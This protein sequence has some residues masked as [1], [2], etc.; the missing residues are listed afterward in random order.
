[1]NRQ[2]SP[3]CSGSCNNRR[4]Q[5]CMNMGRNNCCPKPPMPPNMPEGCCGAGPEMPGGCRNPRPDMRGGCGHP[6]NPMP[7]G[8]CRP[9]PERPGDCCRPKPERPGDCCRPRQERPDDCCCEDN[10]SEGSDSLKGMPVGIG[11][12]PW[13]HWECT[14]SLEDGLCKGTIFPSL[15]L[16]FYGCIPRGYYFKG[17]RA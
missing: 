2:Y 6:K 3:D 12:V 1:M 13:Q 11:Y 14:Y 5:G 7:G 8:C 9:K 4:N 17:G 16:P 10:S 15:D